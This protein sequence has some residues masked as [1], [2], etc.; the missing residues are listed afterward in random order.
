MKKIFAVISIVL[1]TCCTIFCACKKE[2]SCEKCKPVNQPPVANAGKDTSI[3]LPN[4]TAILN[5]SASTDPDNNIV[6]YKWIKIAGPASFIITNDASVQTQVSNL[7]E[8]IYQFELTVTDAKGLSDKDTVSIQ[9]INFGN[10]LFYFPDPTGL[11]PD[12]IIQDQWPIKEGL[13]YLTINNRTDTLFGIW[14]KNYPPIC[15]I[16]Y[17]EL[18]LSIGRTTSVF[19]LP[20][21]AYNW[22][23][24][25]RTIDNN[26]NF[27]LMWGGWQIGFSQ[28]WY[29]PHQTQGTITVNPGDDCI[30]QK[31]VF[32]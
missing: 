14:N 17:V 10:L 20:P 11:M 28:Y 19:N 2:Y 25:S 8:G 30:I 18:V 4:N 3:T 27:F 22:S 29:M 15:P 6:A 32:P 7:T 9:V 16:S 12:N 23:A 13:I 31:I 24:K 21:G 26:D 5:G 1:I